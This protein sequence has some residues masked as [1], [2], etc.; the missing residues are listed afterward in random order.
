MVGIII[1]AIFY[2]CVTSFVAH[3]ATNTLHPKGGVES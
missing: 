2:R 1:G 3:H